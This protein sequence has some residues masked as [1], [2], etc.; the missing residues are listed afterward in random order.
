MFRALAAVACCAA[1]AVPVWSQQFEV[2]SI[3]PAPI[4]TRRR[5]SGTKAGHGRLTMNNVTLKQCIM[6]AWGV[7]PNQIAGGP[8]WLNTDGFEISA[9]ADK[10]VEDEAVINTMLRNLLAERFK[11]EVHR[12]VRNVRALVLEVTKSGPKMEESTDPAA[13]TSS[14]RGSVEGRKITMDRF[15][16]VLARQMEFPVVNRTGL[17]GFFNLDLEWTPLRLSATSPDEPDGPSVFTAIQE[18]LGLRLVAQKMPI[19]MLVIDR[20]EKPEEN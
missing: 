10:P 16:E 7:G 1:A 17:D 4:G 5:G 6:G 3:K 18:Q 11:L 2:A 13:T 9:R 20:A 14:G 12:E 8:A 19:E 15:A